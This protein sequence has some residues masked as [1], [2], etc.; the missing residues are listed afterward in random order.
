[1][2]D[3]LRRHAPAGTLPWESGGPFEQAVFMESGDRRR[4]ALRR[5]DLG[6]R[7]EALIAEACDRECPPSQRCKLDA[8]DLTCAER[9]ATRGRVCQLYHDAY[10]VSVWTS[11]HA[12]Y[13][14]SLDAGILE[15][16][17][18]SVHTVPCA[19]SSLDLSDLYV[20][21]S[22]PKDGGVPK[23][24]Q[25][26]VS[27]LAR[28]TNPGARG[29]DSVLEEALDHAAVRPI[30]QH[31][32]KVCLTGLH[33]QL[34]PASR[35]PWPQRLCALRMADSACYDRADMVRAASHIKEAMRRLLASMMADERPMHVALA[36]LGHPVRHLHQ[37]P[38]QLPHLGMEAAMEAYASAG[39]A[40]GSSEDCGQKLS[41]ALKVSFEQRAAAANK[42]GGA[43]M[44]WA[45][46]WLGKGTANVHAR[47]PLMALA[48]DVWSAAFRAH[49]IAFW[50]FAQQQQLRVS[51]L[52]DVQHAAIHGLNA[53][54]R[55][56]AEL[57]E[58]TALRVQRLA[59]SDPSAGILTISEVAAKLG[60]DS[61]PKS[62]APNGG[63][64]NAE[65]G[66][67]LLALYGARD[68]AKLLCYARVAWLSEELLTVDLG[69]VVAARQMVAL[70]SRYQAGAA[71][72]L[73][74]HAEH[75]C[76]CTECH[77]IANACVASPTD[78][79]FNE[80]GRA[81]TPNPLTLTRWRA[82]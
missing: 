79:P 41:A 34:H 58:A 48:G 26:L 59:L 37:P 77:R 38:S 7:I 3:A 22:N 27:L 1:M 56:A 35:A 61:P 78:V 76:M 36:S 32:V 15:P 69:P 5:V 29:W 20:R 60:I 24:A 31:A 64:R 2:E 52:D 28:C 57:D 10:A 19:A 25:S 44:V 50:L 53:A 43:V 55:L 75:V 21:R 11:A 81:C 72:K 4:A 14:A 8:S 39:T 82:P 45:Q 67:K 51:R 66:A 17:N 6:A 71:G 33:P 65:E 54:T 70:K 13:A 18:P 12:E 9:R 42:D 73:P 40:L 74:V 80:L 47:Q 68:A 16:A 49:F 46:S 23:S 62:T 30:V 63:A